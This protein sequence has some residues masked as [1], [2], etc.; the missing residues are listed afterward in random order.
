MQNNIFNNSRYLNSQRPIGQRGNNIPS[1]N[2]NLRT[3]MLRHLYN[4]HNTITMMDNTSVLLNN[5]YLAEYTT[6]SNS[7]SNYDSPTRRVNPSNLNNLDTSNNI[8]TATTATTATTTTTATTSTTAHPAST[9]NAIFS[10]TNTETSLEQLDISGNPLIQL[11][12]Q[13]LLTNP[14]DIN[15]TTTSIPSLYFPNNE[16]ESQTNVNT[17]NNDQSFTIRLDTFLQPLSEQS[18]RSN[19]QIPDLSYNIKE[20]FANDE[21]CLYQLC[22]DYDLISFER[23][24]MISEPINDIC[25]ITRE[26]FHDEQNALMI[27][28]CKHIFNASSLKIWIRNNN[29]CPSCRTIIRS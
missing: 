5:F 17:D 4:V 20:V 27:C 24:G 8:N 2:I 14:I 16:N 11:L 25:P 28:S 12:L 21:I 29:T 9:N 23:F 3:I 26:R 7:N 6:N 1:H 18:S 22:D 19:N 13:S 15:S 10:D